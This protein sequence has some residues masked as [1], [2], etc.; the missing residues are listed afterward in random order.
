MYFDYAGY[1]RECLNIPLEHLIS[2]ILST[3]TAIIVGIKM[4]HTLHTFSGIRLIISIVVLGTI[5]SMC[6]VMGG[7]YGIVIDGAVG[8]F[9]G[10]GIGVALGAEASSG[11]AI[12]SLSSA[13]SSI[14]KISNTILCKV[15]TLG[16]EHLV[17]PVGIM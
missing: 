17:I 13:I 3:L 6:M 15:N 11:H 10:Y 2:I 4:K 1:V 14:K 16:S 5:E 12:S 8:G 7:I 9:L